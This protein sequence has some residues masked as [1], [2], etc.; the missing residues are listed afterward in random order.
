MSVVFGPVPSR[1]LGRSLG[2][3]NI[4][5][6]VCSFSCVY[7]QA[8]LTKK[9]LA[10]QKNYYSPMIIYAEVK[11]R[12]EELKADNE[13]IDFLSIVP[14]G[15][16]TL[17]MNLEE[18]LYLLQDFG[19]KTAVFTNS[20]LIW[21]KEVQF[22]LKLAD[23]VSIKMD[24]ADDFTWK[25]I[26]RP[27]PSLNLNNILKGISE[28]R[29]NYK[30]RFVTETMLIKDYNDNEDDLIKIGHFIVQIKPDIAYVTIPTRPAA[31]KGIHSPGIQKT[32]S[33]FRIIKSVY[34]DTQLLNIYEGNEF[35]VR[36]NTG[37]SL[38]SIISVHPMR[39]DAV[40]NY[41]SRTNTDWQIIT[42]LIEEDE[43]KEINYEGKTFFVRSKKTKGDNYAE[44]K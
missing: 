35:T 19:I 29:E 8:G 13:K 41:L 5:G 36:D 37:D 26:N 43:I 17:D 20:S 1:R 15:E 42:R 12:L 34:P 32:Y 24:A 44:L 27:H 9:L 11:K 4:I 7:C 21:K 28:F 2:I 16:P 40:E 25:K 33:A 22:A 3:N 30:G 18:T 14:N 10:G 23:Y 39:K 6:K 31:L 38:L